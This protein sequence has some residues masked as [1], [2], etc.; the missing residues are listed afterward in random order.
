[1]EWFSQYTYGTFDTRRDLCSLSSPDYFCHMNRFWG[2]IG[3]GVF[4]YFWHT[5]GKNGSQKNI[6]GWFLSNFLLYF[7]KIWRNYSQR[8]L[9]LIH[10][11]MSV[12]KTVTRIPSCRKCLI[13]YNLSIVC[14]FICH[15]HKIIPTL[16]K[17]LVW[18][19]CV[20]CTE[21]SVH[22]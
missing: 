17:A 18:A 7:F 5:F 11:T 4:F 16:K 10:T 13:G 8:K 20:C 6:F 21:L 3:S 19:A 9:N 12:L 2:Q 14:S 22:Y 15:C 1:M